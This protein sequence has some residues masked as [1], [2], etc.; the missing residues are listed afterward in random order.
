MRRSKLWF[1]SPDGTLMLINP[2]FTFQKI[3]MVQFIF[4]FPTSQMIKGMIANQMP[5]RNYL[6]HDFGVLINI[7]TNA[8]KASLGIKFF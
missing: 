6:I 5:V 8:K 3:L 1:L 2:S 7:V 4:C